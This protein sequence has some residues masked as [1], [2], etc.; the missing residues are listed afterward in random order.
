MIAP[1]RPYGKF[2]ILSSPRSG[3]HMIQ[4]ALRNHPNL[5]AHSE[6]FN[7]DFLHDEPFGP[8]TPAEV[9]LN[10]HIFRPYPP[11]VQKVGF[12]I[13]RSG[14]PF[15]DW[16]NL[17]QSL[18]EDKAIYVVS[19]R[20]RNLLRRYLSYQVMCTFREAPPQ[21]LTFDPEELKS[22]FEY[23]RQEIDLFDQRFAD[24]PLL[25]V[26]YE[27]L[28]EH[29][30]RTVRSVQA[31]LEVKPQKLWPDIEGKPQRALSEAIAN[32]EELKEYFIGTEWAH[33]FKDEEQVRHISKPEYNRWIEEAKWI[34]KVLNI[35]K[36]GYARLFK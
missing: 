11:S 4:T 6:L 2:I 22:D 14:A 1:D 26:H 34:K 28:C 27:D 9:I 17:W 25:K 16:P 33:F 30:H 15:G 3:T 20:R 23:Q 8:G 13:H 18:Q 29:Y 12:I 5:A 35:S 21:P 7:P 24:H 31:F 36:K 32:F 10:Q 19:L